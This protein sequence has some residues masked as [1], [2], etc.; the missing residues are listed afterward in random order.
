MGKKY[1]RSILIL[2]IKRDSAI[3][4]DYGTRK[5]KGYYFYNGYITHFERLNW[6]L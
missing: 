3:L 4:Q 1:S 5:N 2:K 6:K